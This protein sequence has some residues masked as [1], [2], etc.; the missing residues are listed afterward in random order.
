MSPEKRAVCSKGAAAGPRGSP[1]RFPEPGLGGRDANTSRLSPNTSS[2]S[3]WFCLEVGRSLGL[4]EIEDRR[5]IVHG[6]RSR[7]RQG[8]GPSRAK[9]TKKVRGELGAR[10]FSGAWVWASSTRWTDQLRTRARFC[11]SDLRGQL[12]T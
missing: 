1:T 9:R 4:A 7:S 12:L 10:K 11:S 3:L 5:V 8:Q 2:T 6:S